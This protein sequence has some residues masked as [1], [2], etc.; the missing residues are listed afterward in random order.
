MSLDIAEIGNWSSASA[1]VFQASVFRGR[2]LS[3]AAT[4]TI[5]SELCVPLSDDLVRTMA[6]DQTYANDA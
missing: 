1:G 4:A 6:L 3:E 2:E 5:S